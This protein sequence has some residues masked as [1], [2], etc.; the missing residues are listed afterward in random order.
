MDFVSAMRSGVSPSMMSD[1]MMSDLKPLA[2]LW[3]EEAD[4]KEKLS[5]DPE[6]NPMKAAAGKMAQAHE[7]QHADYSK[8][9]NEFLNS[10]SV[11]GLKG[12]DRHQAIQK[13]KGEWKASNPEHEAGHQAVSETQQAF[14]ENKGAAKQSLQDKIAHITSGG[15]SMPT[16]MSANEAMQHLGGGKSEEGYQGQIVSDPSASFA[17]RNPKLLAALKPEQQERLKAVDSAAK[18]LGKVRVRKGGAQ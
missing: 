11:K 15:Q 2:K 16:E 13:W 12:K 10:D 17:A 6:V 9:Y 5:A 18:S 1:K 14:K 7:T 3:L 4:K 8:A